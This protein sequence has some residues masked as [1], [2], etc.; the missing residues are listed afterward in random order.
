VVQ[1]DFELF[2]NSDD[3]NIQLPVKLMEKVN[4]TYHSIKNLNGIE[5]EEES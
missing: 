5:I 2:K 4:E 3:T 1:F